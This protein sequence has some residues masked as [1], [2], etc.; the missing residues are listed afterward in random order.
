MKGVDRDKWFTISR[1][2]VLL[3][4]GTVMAA[5]VMCVCVLTEIFDLQNINRCIDTLFKKSVMW[6]F[7]RN[8]CVVKIHTLSTLTLSRS[9]HPVSTFDRQG[10]L[11]CT[12]SWTILLYLLGN[13]F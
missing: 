4:D 1:I 11:R 13:R 2:A 9:R 10:P 5:E 3:G 12:E 8:W 6:Y 7:Y